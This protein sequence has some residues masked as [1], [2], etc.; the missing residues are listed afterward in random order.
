MGEMNF[1][2]I[3][4][5]V[6]GEQE[7]AIRLLFN[8]K[9]WP[10]WLKVVAAEN[11]SDIIQSGFTDI[12]LTVDQY[13]RAGHHGSCRDSV[14]E[15]VKSESINIKAEINTSC[16]EASSEKQQHSD[17]KSDNS[18]SEHS[19]SDNLLQV[20]EKELH[21]VSDND[22]KRSDNNNKSSDNMPQSSDNEDTD[23][24]YMNAD[25]DMGSSSSD[26][27]EELSNKLRIRSSHRKKDNKQELSS[28]KG[29]SSKKS[30]EYHSQSLTS[31]INNRS[32]DES[33]KTKFRCSMCNRY[34]ASKPS[35]LRHC[36]RRHGDEWFEFK[37]KD[38]P[39]MFKKLEELWKHRNE[40]KHEPPKVQPKF[41]EKK[42]L[43]PEELEQLG[44]IKCTACGKILPSRRLLRRHFYSDHRECMPGPSCAVCGAEFKTR[45]ELW[46]HKREMKHNDSLSLL[47][48]YQCEECGKILTG[49]YQSFKLHQKYACKDTEDEPQ[50]KCD[51]CGGMFKSEVHVQQH[52]KRTHSE[53]PVVC[54]ICGT[55][56]KNKHALNSHKRRHNEKNKKFV[57]NSCGKAFLTNILLK[58]HI[59]THTKEKPY[60]CPLCDYRCA[61]KQNIQ[62]HSV[63]VHKTQVKCADIVTISET[64][65][66]SNKIRLLE[67]TDKVYDET[68]DMKQRS[69]QFSPEGVFLP[70]DTEQISNE[71]MSYFNKVSNNLN[72]AETLSNNGSLLTKDRILL[73]ND[74]RKGWKSM[75]SN[76]SLFSDEK[77][78]NLCDKDFKSYP[79]NEIEGAY[80]LSICRQNTA[81]SS[82]NEV[83]KVIVNTES[84]RAN[85]NNV[86]VTSTGSYTE[87][88]NCSI[89]PVTYANTNTSHYPYAWE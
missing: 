17:Y 6:C 25:N 18:E 81:S 31:C 4:M 45:Q 64:G 30:S 24:D 78:S 76:K 75:T 77:R 67:N 73:T 44:H 26:A 47:Q 58:M 39:C 48:T 35:L 61:I 86:K 22:N 33:K 51:L 40:V 85:V 27:I 8:D 68:R 34:L 12:F 74:M 50:I 70:D 82:G 63:N 13:S 71:R 15:E 54:D 84:A 57:C 88:V 32:S 87:L 49:G 72:Y 89:N 14:F 53:L 46:K 11:V 9:K 36:Q 20:S 66:S 19:I 28:G 41:S 80:D 65:L 3:T 43:S 37:C 79:F 23:C 29:K 16:Q 2:H 21:V 83:D 55:I 69:L 7:S 60:K 38:C 59:R 5:L 62:K 42:N 56:C 52:I 1:Y 10:C